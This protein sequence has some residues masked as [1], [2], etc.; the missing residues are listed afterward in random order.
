[1]R[2]YLVVLTGDDDIDRESGWVGS[3]AEFKEVERIAGDE[4]GQQYCRTFR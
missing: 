4:E 1:M 3:E 2:G